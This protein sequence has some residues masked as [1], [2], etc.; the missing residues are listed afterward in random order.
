MSILPLSISRKNL[1]GGCKEGVYFVKK[2]HA[3]SESKLFGVAI[4]PVLRCNI[5]SFALPN[6]GY[7][8]VLKYR[9]LHDLVCLKKCLHRCGV[10]N[11]WILFFVVWVSALRNCVSCSA[12]VGQLMNDNLP[13]S[14]KHLRLKADHRLSRNFY[15]DV[16][17]DAIN[18]LLAAAAYNFKRA[19]RVLLYLIKRISI[20]LVSTNFMLKYSF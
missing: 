17:G 14:G 7:C 12:M 3:K 19:M 18:V 20:E 11:A 9:K 10:E 16:K 15:K 13:S 8:K 5:G 4:V 6:K 2:A 1:Y